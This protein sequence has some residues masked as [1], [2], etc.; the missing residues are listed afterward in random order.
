MTNT[1]YRRAG[2]TPPSIPIRCLYCGGVRL[3]EDAPCGTC[4]D[5]QACDPRA[6]SATDQLTCPRCK[7]ALGA[8]ALDGTVLFQCATCLG[9]FVSVHA[10]SDI[11]H[12]I[13][14]GQP[15][16]LSRFVPLPPGR[17][18]ETS[19]LLASVACCRCS[20]PSERVTFGVRSHVVVDICAAHGIW[21]D[22]AEITRAVQFVRAR[23]QNHG[24]VPMSDA[25]R[26]EELQLARVNEER[27]LAARAGEARDLREHQ[28]RQLYDRDPTPVDLG[29]MFSWLWP[30]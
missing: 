13:G 7:I 19:A 4:G 26:R 18:L 27:R 15:A 22:A 8:I 23:E 5:A 6:P 21:F 29:D 2:G 11:L 10:W 12:R 3:A 25:E 1:P 14:E 30:D 20:K 17:E 9:G 28:L 16:P 24:K